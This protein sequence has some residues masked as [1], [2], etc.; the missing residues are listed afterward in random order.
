MKKKPACLSILIALGLVLVLLSGCSSVRA[1]LKSNISGI[2]YWYYEPQ[3][4]VGKG[5]VGMNGEGTATTQRQA[6]LIAYNNIIE[7]LSE[8]IGS[9]IGQEAYRELS[10]LGTISEYGLVLE[11]SYVNTQEG[12]YNVFLHVSIDQNLLDKATTDET[13]RREIITKQV[14]DLVLKGDEYV[15][16]GNEI[17]AVSNYMKAMALSEGKDY[18]DSEYQFK[19][20]Y[21]V[22][23]QLLKGVTLTI[24]SS[25]TDVVSCVVSITRKGTFVSSAVASAEVLASYQAEDV[26][27]MIYNDSF[28]YVSDEGGLFVFN[29]INDSILRKGSVR[30]ELNLSKELKDLEAAVGAENV[31]DLRALIDSK[32]IEFEYDKKYSMGSIAVAVIEHD[33]LG[34]VTGVTDITDYVTARLLSDDAI[35][36]AFYAELD[37]EMDVSYEFTHSGR[38]EECLLVMRIGITNHVS[39]RQNFEVAGAEGIFYLFVRGKEEPVYTS[40]VIYASAYADTYKDAVR[41]AFKALADIAYSLVKAVYV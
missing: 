15:K 3:M 2:P 37:D 14:N 38:T 39:S 27:G 8:R 28:V 1:V 9:E 29:P 16:A 11:D 24:V 7:K 10:V 35:A 6:E 5:R 31:A 22:V 41:G 18:I 12:M 21:P 13:K 17:R 32:T 36:S 30:F 19:E 20:L 23:L 25:R 34:Y 33:N 40:D 4:G 26:R